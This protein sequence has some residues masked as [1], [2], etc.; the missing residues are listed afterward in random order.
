ME[1]LTQ[2]NNWFY[3]RA[4][5]LY[6][7]TL[8]CALITTALMCVVGLYLW[9]TSQS[10]LVGYWLALGLIN[11]ICR[12]IFV[13]YIEKKFHTV[14]KENLSKTLILLSSAF[15]SFIWCTC[16]FLFINDSQTQ[17]NIFIVI[18]ILGLI[19]T[20]LPVQSTYLPAFYTFS[21]PVFLALMYR[22]YQLDMP[23]PALSISLCFLTFMIISYHCHRSIMQSL[24]L[25]TNST[26][27]VSHHIKK[28]KR[29]IEEKQK[30]IQTNIEN[31]KLIA[32]ASH[33]LR[34]PIHAMGLCLEALENQLHN[35]EES[36]LILEKLKTCHSNFSDMFNT[37]LDVSQLDLAHNNP[38]KTTFD[39]NKMILTLINEFNLEAKKKNLHIHYRAQTHY[40]HSDPNLLSRLI[41]N[42]ISNAIKYTHSGSVIIECLH[43]EQGLLFQISDTGIG[44]PEQYLK[45]IFDIN[46]QI[47]NSKHDLNSG[48][49]LGLAVV[50]KISDIL[51]LNI[52]VD[53]IINK[54]T[55]FS[56]TLP[57][58]E[59]P[60]ESSI[61]PSNTRSSS[62]NTKQPK[63]MVIEDDPTT[64][65]ILE[66]MLDN[67]NCTPLLAQNSEE[68][69]ALLKNKEELPDLILSDYRLNKDENGI[70]TIQSIWD[71]LGKN[72]P[73]IMITGD[74]CPLL[75]KKVRKSGI[76]IMY[77][78]LS[79]GLLSH[80]LN[81]ARSF[82]LA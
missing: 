25:A 45:S 29:A 81:R 38:I 36:K 39:I 55:C 22:F 23:A 24:E 54:G 27:L 17:T 19:S 61:Q 44:I 73:A 82:S 21:F 10:P 26:K 70:S 18:T 20:V 59:K 71:V 79:K 77:K 11:V 1:S 13:N 30:A 72:I 60:M 57:Y 33:D 75:A 67:A 40:I 62:I 9:N 80:A 49:G 76:M 42:L 52:K 47:K 3:P 51:N 35:P 32:T 43:N 69:L 14:R 46:F 12:F 31:T 5:Y 34:Q 74:T 37:V 56:F 8:S 41:R 16:A 53:S 63:V 48:A 78:P 50:H 64:L 28:R 65:D 7:H 68:A 2:K 66:S 15:T 4:E 6:K 58:S